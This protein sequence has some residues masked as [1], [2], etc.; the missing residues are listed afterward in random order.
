MQGNHGQDGFAHR[1]MFLGCVREPNLKKWDL[2][3]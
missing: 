2:M 1:A 3:N